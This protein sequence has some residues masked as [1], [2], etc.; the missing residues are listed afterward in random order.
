MAPFLTLIE[1]FKLL[2][3]ETR[4]KIL[5][6]LADREFSAGEIS[7][8]LEMHPSAVSNQL[9]LLKKNGLLKSRK[10][11]TRVFYRPARTNPH[12]D[13]MLL[14]KVF[15][16]GQEE[17]L[18]DT[19]DRAIAAIMEARR[20]S[21]LNFFESLSD[22]D[23]APGEGTEPL[24]EGLL[25]LFPPLVLADLGC[26]RGELTARLAAGGHRVTGVDNSPRRIE[27]AKVL[28][29]F[30]GGP[31]FI[32]ADMDATGLPDG[33]QDGVILSQS[34]HHASDPLRV[35]MEGR[36]ILKPG[37]SLLI[38]DLEAHNHEEFRRIWGDLWLGFSPK[39]L[40]RLLEDSGLIPGE[41]VIRRC[42]SR[43]KDIGTLVLCSQKPTHTTGD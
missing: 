40:K 16:R 43:F 30:P 42:D 13:K 12:I 34:L 26:G 7:E 31:D 19:E 29:A 1:T 8:A 6:L 9:T 21:S 38:I 24:A 28:A 10:E 17:G 32:L 2:G 3:D 22:A 27:E 35:L 39:D 4:I 5:H 41:P 25:R 23:P 36:R 33:S 14:E 37:G 11:G 15:T 20:R 18:F